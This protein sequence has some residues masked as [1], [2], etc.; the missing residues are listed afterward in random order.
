MNS[1]D[2]LEAARLALQARLDGEKSQ[3]DRN[4][5]GQFATP[6][7]LADDI[8]SYANTLLPEGAPV[9]FI[10]P[11]I[12]TGAF[13]SALRRTFP[14]RQIREA[15]GIEID[16]HYGE[17]ARELWKGTKLK[18]ELGDFTERTGDARFN[19]LICNPPYVRHHHMP[20]EYKV[21]LQLRSLKACGKDWRPRGPLLLF[22]RALS[23]MARAGSYIR[24]ADS[25]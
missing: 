1:A 17:P 6:T 22:R 4:K 12:G 7:Q 5:L 23:R 19:L 2:T 16:P 18:Y 11:A 8:L 15:S 3:A 13:Y 20:N 14:T 9:H 25:Q 21:R 24:L 10:D